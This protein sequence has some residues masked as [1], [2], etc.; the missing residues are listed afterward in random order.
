MTNSIFQFGFVPTY[1]K[2]TINYSKASFYNIVRSFIVNKK[3]YLVRYFRYKKI[4]KM[5]SKIK[6][7]DLSELT[8]LVRPGKLSY[9]K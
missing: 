1:Q 2:T 6:M 5:L 4:M 3:R 7:E 9:L 8:K